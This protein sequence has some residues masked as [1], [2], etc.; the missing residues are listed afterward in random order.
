MNRLA[1]M[2][3]LGIGV[4]LLV[5]GC[6]PKS[7]PPMEVGIWYWHTPF[8]VS[9]DDA[10]WLDKIGVTT[11]YVRAATFTSDG[12]R[13][14]TS[15]PQVWRRNESAIPVVLT[16]NFD[17]GLRSH[18]GSMPNPELSSDIAAGI[19]RIRSAA[20]T[21]GIRVSGIQMDV[22]CPTRLLAKYADLLHKI[23]FHLLM[24]RTLMARET[25]S[26]TALQTW[27][28]SIRY[29]DLVDSCD[30]V[31]P[32]FYEGQVGRRIDEVHPIADTG[33]IEQ[34]MRRADS[35]G[36]PFFAGLATYG[37]SL[38]Y[39]E[40]GRLLAM[41]HG[42]KPEDALRHPS[43]QVDTECPIG[44]GGARAT[45]SDYVGENLLILNAVRPDRNGRGLGYRIAYILP[46]V[47]M[48][49]HELKVF[50]ETRPE[51][52]RGVILYRYPEPEDQMSL[53][54]PTVAEAI[55]GGTGKLDLSAALNRTAIPWPLIGPDRK[56]QRPPCEYTVNLRSLGTLPTLTGRDAVTVLV[57]FERQGLDGVEAGD[58]DDAQTGIV[59]P[60][61]TF[62]QCSPAHAD[63]V[64]LLRY[65]L[66][67]GRRINSGA[68]QVSAD[69]PKP[70]SI[71]WTALS[72]DG[73]KPISET[74]RLV[75]QSPGKLSG[76]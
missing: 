25:F 37:H 55:L 28:K 72:G 56:A 19:G 2:A 35:A 73:L 68:I 7:L 66:L 43:L 36:K 38:L 11:L 20:E 76:K 42:M 14:K 13:V 60:S 4:V 69:G 23:R 59:E 57:R 74:E 15:I 45:G 10:K 51:N 34:G 32:Q 61:G 24:Q 62:Q 16:F 53:P 50:R 26:A 17:G 9:K 27:L 1:Q 30:F 63:S 49:A 39:D 12:K 71:T 75:G 40:H 44:K 6:R 54:L 67:P 41:Y 18:F 52:C 29:R 65:S 22:D 31:A 33:N 58:F 3:F 21:H 64:L 48:L 47:E 70:E 5:V 46:T 8:Q